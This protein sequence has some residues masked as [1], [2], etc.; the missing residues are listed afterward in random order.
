MRKPEVTEN[1]LSFVE[2]KQIGDE[3][4]V[5]LSSSGKKPKRVYIFLWIP[6]FFSTTGFKI[7]D[8]SIFQKLMLVLRRS[9]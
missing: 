3:V 9:F 2:K 4:T 6:L 8:S 1:S 7:I 5:P